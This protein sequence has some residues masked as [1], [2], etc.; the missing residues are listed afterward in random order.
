MKLIRIAV[1]LLVAG[2]VLLFVT[3]GKIFHIAKA[4]PFC[5]GNPIDWSYELGGLV[6]LG[7]FLWGLYR[8]RRNNN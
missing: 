2:T 1:V 6:L 7:L 5:S 4:L 3:G 8:I